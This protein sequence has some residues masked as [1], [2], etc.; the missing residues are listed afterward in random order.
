MKKEIYTDLEKKIELKFRNHNGVEYTGCSMEQLIDIY[1]KENMIKKDDIWYRIIPE[2]KDSVLMWEISDTENRTINVWC[3][4]A[5]EN[6][7]K[8]AVEKFKKEI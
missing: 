4:N 5:E 2:T 1:Y 7:L 8:Q 3:I 6:S